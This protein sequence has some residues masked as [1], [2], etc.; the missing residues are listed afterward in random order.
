ML[1]EEQFQELLRSG[2]HQQISAELDRLERQHDWKT[3]VLLALS[4]PVLVVAVIFT[5]L[6]M[7][8]LA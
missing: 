7:V 4:D 3:S 8:L 1:S 2:D 5:V 6:L